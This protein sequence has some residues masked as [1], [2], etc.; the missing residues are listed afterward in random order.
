M[1]DFFDNYLGPQKKPNCVID[2]NMGMLGVDRHDQV[3]ASFP[4][5]RKFLKGYKKIFFYTCDMAILNSFILCKKNRSIKKRQT[6]SNYRLEIAEKLLDMVL[7]YQNY[8]NVDKSNQESFIVEDTDMRLEASHRAHFPKHIDST[9]KKK[10]PT[11]IC[12]V[13]FKHEK[14]S[15]TK[16][17]CKKCLVA[18]HVPECFEKY[19]TMED[20]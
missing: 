17:E 13:R 18:L 20:Y 3:L 11:R 2:Y 8:Y 12:K 19:H 14:R 6:Y 4:I 7:K 16:W 15:E 9:L 5:M 10:N 1:I